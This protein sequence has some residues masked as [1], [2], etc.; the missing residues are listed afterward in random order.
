MELTIATLFLVGYLSWR[1]GASFAPRSEIREGGEWISRGEA[2]ALFTMCILAI[3]L[4]A[5]SYI[6][7]IEEGI[8]FTQARF[9][10]VELTIEQSI[11]SV[12]APHLQL[13]T[14]LLLGLLSSVRHRDI[15]R[16]SRMLLIVYGCLISIVMALSSQ[17]RSAVTAMCFLYIA[18]KFF[19]RE[20][21]KLWHVG[22]VGVLGI[23][24]LLVVQGLRIVNSAEFSDAPNQLKFAV[25]NVIP[26]T[27]VTLSGE[28]EVLSER[29]LSRGGGTIAF[30]AEI[31]TEIDSRGSAFYGQGILQSL[32][33]LIPR[34]IWPDKHGG[35]S[36]QF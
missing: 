13:P 25:E 20:A 32:F 30:L 21:T 22:V 34:F 16:S 27:I 15:A 11:V 24:T 23:V 4:I 9:V 33:G 18:T 36:P 28:S 31:V 10:E 1:S 17:T 12:L 26:S 6:W 2:W 3:G 29:L 14:I 19:R 5:Y 8:F 35:T 7:T